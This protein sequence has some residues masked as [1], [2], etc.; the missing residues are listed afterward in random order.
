MTTSVRFPR[1]TIAF[2]A[3]L[4]AAA[5]LGAQPSDS[6]LL[7]T[8][9]WREVGPANMGGRIVDIEAVE[10]DF[11]TV[12]LASASGGVFRSDNAGTTWQPIFDRYP[13]ASIGDIAIFQ[14]DPSI[15]WVGTGE[16]NNRNSVGWGDGIYKSTD[17]GATF[18]RMGLASTHQ[19][20]RVVT[21]PTDPHIVYVA[22]I[23]H[24]WGYSGDRGLFR[25][26][27]GG[28][29][30]TKLGGGL[31]DDGRTGATDLVMDPTDPNTLYVAFYHRL[32]RPWTFHSGGPNGGIFKSTD[33]GRSWRKLTNG[34]P[35]GETG[36][37]GLA[38]HRRNPRILM[39][40]VEAERRTDLTVP[41]S[42][43]YRSEDA[44]ESWR[45]VNT[46]NN[47]PFYYSQIRINPSND[48][49]VYVLTTRFMISE[50]GGRT[51]ANGSE[52]QEIHGDFHAMWLDPDDE[53]RYYIGADK[54]ASLTHDGRHFILF[55]NLAIAQYYR[56][57]VDMRDPYYIYGGHQD[58]GTWG[59]PSFSRD[60]RG[61]LN[62]ANW[63]LHWGDGQDV[64]VDPTNWRA[65][66][67]ETENGGFRFY[68]VETHRMEGRRPAASN[69]I[70]FAAMFGDST[71]AD[72][73][74][75]FNWSA[76]LV[77]S[78]HDPSTLYLGGNHLFRT[79]SRG[80][81]W[82]I[83][84][85]DLSKQ[86]PEKIVRGKSGGITPDNTG[87]ETHGSITTVAESPV[88]PGVIWVG[89]DDGNVQLT[90]DHGATW[91]NV[92]SRIRGVPDGIWVDRIEA[93]HFDPATAYV[94][95]DGHRSDIVRPWVFRTGDYGRSWREITNDLPRDQPVHVIREDR[96]NPALLFAGSETSVF[97]SLD[98]GAHWIR[99]NHGLPT[100]AVLDLVIHRRDADLI[101]GTH[102]RSI[103]ILDDI[104]PLQQLSP[105]V[106]A[107][108]AH[109]FEQ[110]PA[111]LWENLS[112]GGQR[113]HDWFAGDNPPTIVPT[114]SLPRA[115]FRNSA[116]I[117]YYLKE[118]VAGAVLLIEDPRTGRSHRAALPAAAGIHRYRWT[119]EFD[120]PPGVAGSTDA[121]ERELAGP[122]T[123]RLTLTA[124]GARATATLVVRPD[125][126]HID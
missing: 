29:T 65:L 120:P 121:A 34:L 67:T 12:F 60:A 66:Y 85:P 125:P 107:A 97:A 96:R 61:I 59:G 89:T 51:L 71:S 42:G 10:G 4:L 124:G 52:D 106:R 19:I 73:V 63:K 55:D 109:L 43:I 28:I 119:L 126:M 9:R 90:R 53:N 110:R 49:K 111:T 3:L 114:S 23:G 39:A 36:R 64:Q 74:F 54:G 14:P 27:D 26:T 41:G 25:T 15:I 81:S 91:S 100:V 57:G 117:S 93:S 79:R 92:R 24:L 115:Q 50:D 77:M 108:A 47:R 99:I 83:I 58:N 30:W 94:T 5:P 75:R 104:S 86:E 102:G 44:G 116:L 69:V 18:S 21:H 113:G 72:S 2:A 37:I 112:R 80:E 46:Y 6:A 40:I 101:A 62:D 16:A 1:R 70:G 48:Q 8:F 87:A 22:A 88:V 82:T 123:Y 105:A 31:P 35:G 84:S 76:P 20:A 95:F 103:W 122:G 78:P 33:G 7:S 56:I 98:S 38:I 17:G 13:S 68:D 11:A 118:P 45:Y 32:R